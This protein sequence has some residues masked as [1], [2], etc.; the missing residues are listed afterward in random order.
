MNKIVYGLIT[1]SLLTTTFSMIN[2]HPYQGLY[3]NE[4]IDMKWAK[5]NFPIDYWGLTIREGLEWLVEHDDRENIKVYT[6]GMDSIYILNKDDME[7]VTFSLFNING[8]VWTLDADYIIN[9]YDHVQVDY[10]YGVEAYTKKINGASIMQV[11]RLDGST[12][13]WTE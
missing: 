13:Y 9:N 7:R 6:Y 10:D 3:F 2:I 11:R 8:D 5:Q 4:I 12:L 1:I